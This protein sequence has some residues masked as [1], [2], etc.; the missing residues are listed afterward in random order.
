MCMITN[1][2]PIKP[3]FN[4]LAKSPYAALLRILCHC[5]VRTNTPRSSGFE[6]LAYGAFYETVYLIYFINWR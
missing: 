3:P 6:R 2:V 1:N 4:G 5:G